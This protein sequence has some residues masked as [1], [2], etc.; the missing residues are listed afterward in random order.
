LAAGLT[1]LEVKRVLQNTSLPLK[2]ARLS[3]LSRAASTLARCA[4]LQYSSWPLEMNTLWVP[5]SDPRA[6]VSTP[7]M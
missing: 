6:C 4:P 5:S 1:V 2:K 3:P 7:D